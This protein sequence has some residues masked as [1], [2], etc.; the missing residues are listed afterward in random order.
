MASHYGSRWIAAGPLA[1]P[2]PFATRAGPP[3]RVSALMIERARLA[4]LPVLLYHHVS[5]RRPGTPASLTVSPARFERQVH[6]LARRGYVG[7][8]PSD[9]WLRC[10]EGTPLPSKP[11][12]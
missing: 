1:L 12:L 10:M 4:R 5:P 3:S 6:W 9:W 8:S 2:C 7:I 11:V